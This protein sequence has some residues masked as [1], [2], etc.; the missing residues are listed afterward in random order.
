VNDVELSIKRTGNSR[1]SPEA[2]QTVELLTVLNCP[3]GDFGEKV[4][5]NTT[6]GEILPTRY[7]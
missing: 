7:V 4:D 2:S 6:I 3:E 1:E 5:L